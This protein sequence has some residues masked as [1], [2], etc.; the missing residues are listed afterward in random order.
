MW[1]NTFMW[2]LFFCLV[3]GRFQKKEKKTKC[4]VVNL[5]S[6]SIHATLRLVQLTTS[7]V[8]KHEID[9]MDFLISL[10]FPSYCCYCLPIH[11]HAEA[12]SMQQAR[13]N[14]SSVCSHSVYTVTTQYYQYSSTVLHICTA[15][16]QCSL[17]VTFKESIASV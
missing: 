17:S 3:C 10:S 15:L 14:L 8:L 13:G 2:H 5:F 16:R 7:K 4:D 11:C 1:S 6:A 12:I 9:R